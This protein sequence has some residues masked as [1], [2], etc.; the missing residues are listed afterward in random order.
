M[1]ISRPQATI[2]S[3]YVHAPNVACA[4]F[5]AEATQEGVPKTG[6]AAEPHSSS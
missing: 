1:T 5:E 4:H 3:V 2:D 6:G